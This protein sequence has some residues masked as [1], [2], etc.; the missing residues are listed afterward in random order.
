MLPSLRKGASK[1]AVPLGTVIGE[2]AVWMLG[3]E[4]ARSKKRQRTGAVQN[5]AGILRPNGFYDLQAFA[6]AALQ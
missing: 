1:A 2:F 4:F 6:D 3:G 5:L